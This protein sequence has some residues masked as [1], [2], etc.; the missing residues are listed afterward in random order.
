MNKKILIA[1]LLVIV[2]IFI[3][4][5]FFSFLNMG[6]DGI[7]SKIYINNYDVSNLSKSEANDKLEE[8]TNANMTKKITFFYGNDE[9][10]SKSITISN[11]SPSYNVNEA[12]SSA[13]NYG[14]L[15]NIFV[16][17]F[18]IAKALFLGKTFN[19]DVEFKENEF[20]ELISDI[21]ANL[22]NKLIQ[23]GYY[24]DHDNLII[25]KGAEG[26]IVDENTFAKNLKMA[27]CSFTESDLKMEIPVVSAKP[28]LIDF[29]K[30][31]SEIYKEA[32][33]AHFDKEPFKVY[34][35]VVGIDFDVN[36][37]IKSYTENSNGQDFSIKLDVT[38]PKVHL[39]ELDIDVF[40]DLLGSFSSNYSTSDK[41]RSTNL[42]LAASK[43]D[44][45]IL[46]PGEEFSYN[47]IVGE[48][49]ISAG[50]KE[51][52]IYVSG[53]IVDGLGGGICQVS[54][55]LYNTAVFAN[56]EITER[57]NHQFT[58][59]YS[60]PGRDA[61]VAYGSKDFK[62]VN[63][64]QY[65]IKISAIVD[66]GVVKISIFGIKEDTDFDIE[67]DVDVITE[68]PF[69]TIYETDSSLPSDSEVV[70]QYGIDGIVVDSYIVKKKNGITVSRDFI[71][72]DKYNALDEIVVKNKNSDVRKDL[73]Y[74]N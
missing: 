51:A 66:S 49:S 64:R 24:I 67:F 41:D 69:K 38:E 60:F 13:Y 36:A 4:S 39:S 65:P 16:N 52:K 48:R 17:N 68:L 61:T 3:F 31:H 40:P 1:L 25:T 7:F 29:E 8:L 6:N 32:K 72:N 74:E 63:N 10:Y 9:N 46:S 56:L 27:V 50:Y 34:S 42:S 21:S 26:L 37:A 28:E 20:K 14:R 5:V 22:P 73:S 55:T 57:H 18:H 23:S 62:F 70:K 30:I 43:I 2:F 59:S 12:V 35:E 19:L 15:N 33:D 47:K 44:G 11:L 54:S 71:S 45:L 58:T 53:K